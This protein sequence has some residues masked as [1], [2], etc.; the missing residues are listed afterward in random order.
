MKIRIT[1]GGG[2][3]GSHLAER[4]IQVGHQTMVLD[5]FSTVRRKKI[6]ILMNLKDFKLITGSI[7][8]MPLISVLKKRKA[9]IFLLAAAVKVFGIVSNPIASLSIVESDFAY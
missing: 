3:I 8:D 6:S 7:L 5:D 1:G 9:F 4:L 2:F